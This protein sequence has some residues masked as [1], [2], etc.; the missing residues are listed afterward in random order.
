MALLL[1]HQIQFYLMDL[2]THMITQFMMDSI[3]NYLYY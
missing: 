2:K 1:R 3:P